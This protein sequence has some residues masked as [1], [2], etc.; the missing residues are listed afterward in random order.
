MRSS[1]ATGLKDGPSA[2]LLLAVAAI[3]FRPPAIRRVVSAGMLIAAAFLFRPVLGISGLVMMLAPAIDWARRRDQAL[4]APEPD[5][6]ARPA[7]R[8]SGAAGAVRRPGRPLSAHPGGHHR[9]RDDPR[10]GHRAG[11][12]ELQLLP[13]RFSAR[14]ARSLPWSFGP[15]ADSVYLAL[16]PGMVIWILM[17]PA[18]ALGCWSFSGGGRGQHGASWCPPWPSCTCTRPCSRTRDSSGSDTRSRSRCWSCACTPSTVSAR[19]SDR[20]GRRRLCGCSRGAGPGARAFPDR[21]DTG[22]GRP[23]GAV[24]CAPSVP[25]PRAARHPMAR[26]CTAGP[27]RDPGQRRSRWVRNLS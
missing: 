3:A 25:G 20:D 13:V 6:P 7:H 2:T 9:Q 26:T 24:V 10:R 23:G 18:T 16:Y 11:D 27:D 5:A 15:T 17:L 14:A 12:G 22:R 8:A 19:G 21:P 1:G 4:S